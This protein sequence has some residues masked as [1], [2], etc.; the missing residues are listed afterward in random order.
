MQNPE[1]RLK[2]LY[3]MSIVCVTL[4]LAACGAPAAIPLTPASVATRAPGGSSTAAPTV[5]LSQLPL[6]ATA[7]AVPTQVLPPTSTEAPSISVVVLSAQLS[8]TLAA[9]LPPTSTPDASDM[10]FGGFSGVNVL[11]LKTAKDQPPLWAAFTYGPRSFDPLQNHFVSIFTHTEAGWQ[12]LSRLDLEAP[13]YIDPAHVWLEVQSGV[14]AH[15]GCYDLLRLDG[16]VLTDTV[17]NCSSSPGAGRVADVNGDGQLDVVLDRTDSYVFCYACGVRFP[18]F[19]VMRWDGRQL[20]EVQLTSLPDSTPVELRQAINHAVELAQAGLWK[21][22]SAAVDQV[23][24]LSAPDETAQWDAALIRW[25]AKALQDQ[26]DN[27]AYPLL[28][29]LFYGDYAAALQVLRAFS[30]EQ[31]FG[32]DTPL[33]TGTVAEG[34]A[35]SVTY[36][37]TS[38]TTSALSVEPNLAA[39]YFIQG[40]GLHLADPAS[41]DAVADI[42]K[43]AQLDPNEPLYAQS[44]AYLK[45]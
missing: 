5:T 30:P 2:R 31:L 22:A 3:L 43:A 36:W 40:W 44:L 28:D 19:V 26:I 17:Q 10:V 27:Q 11:P 45:K 9:Q 15:G 8:A 7:T 39:A 41:A 21:D 33:I 24:A 34:W 20:V 35:D 6:L 37:V 12:Q 23:A 13:D 16:N 29:Q 14:G 32:P 42:E 4:I 38:T 25:Q 18:D 1:C